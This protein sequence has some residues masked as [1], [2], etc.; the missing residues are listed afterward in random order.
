MVY[1]AREYEK[2]KDFLL[3]DE[4]VQIRGRYQDVE[5]KAMIA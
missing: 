4:Y 5:H 2:A 3:E 1:S